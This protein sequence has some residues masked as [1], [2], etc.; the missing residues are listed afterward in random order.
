MSQQKTMTGINTPFCGD[1][2]SKNYFL[3]DVIPTEES[4]Y[5]GDSHHC[6]CFHTQQAI[7]PDRGIVLPNRCVPGR[8]C[9]RSALSE[10]KD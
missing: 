2:R 10:P 4:Q 9:Y 1:L 8:K 5:M 3:L 6:W 7:G